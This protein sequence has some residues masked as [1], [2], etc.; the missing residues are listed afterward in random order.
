MTELHSKCALLNSGSYIMC[1]CFP[2]LSATLLIIKGLWINWN[3][4]LKFALISNE[5]FQNCQMFY[6]TWLLQTDTDVGEWL[7]EHIR[8]SFFYHSLIPKLNVFC[9]RCQVFNLLSKTTIF[10]NKQLSWNLSLISH[11]KAQRND[12]SFCSQ[13]YKFLIFFIKSN[14]KAIEISQNEHK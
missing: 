1:F 2:F 12:P 4:L 14:D 10:L 9:K 3:K 11:T 8:A 6:R 7:N 5:C 13:L